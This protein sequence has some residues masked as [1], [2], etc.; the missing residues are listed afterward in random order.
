MQAVVLAVWD[1]LEL[2]AELNA[3][4]KKLALDGREVIDIKYATTN[5]ATQEASIHY[6]VC[7][8]YR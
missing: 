2:E 6:S 5:D 7:I 3:E 8:L 1:S 4:L